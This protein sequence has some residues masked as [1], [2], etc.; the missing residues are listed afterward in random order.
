MNTKTEKTKREVDGLVH[1]KPGSVDQQAED[2]FPA[3]DAPTFS[4]GAIG[5]PKDR[6][7]PPLPEEDGPEKGKKSPAS[8]DKKSAA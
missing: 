8:T 4:P 3:S 2:S 1:S 5:A 7:T 6:V